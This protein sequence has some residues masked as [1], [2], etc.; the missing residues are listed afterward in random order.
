M[1]DQMEEL[2]ARPYADWLPM[3]GGRSHPRDTPEAADYVVEF[4][5]SDDPCHPRNWP[6]GR[7]ALIAIIACLGSFVACFDSAIFAAGAE[8]A[9]QELHVSSEVIALGTSLFVLGFSFGPLFAPM[10][11]MVGRRWPLLI[12]MIGTS[13]FAIGCATAKD[14][15]TLLICRFF[16]G[17]FGS[18]PLCVAP[19]VLADLYNS[20]Y[21]GVAVSLYALTVYGG[22]FLG[23]V[24]G[25]QLATSSL[26]W[27]WSLYL[28]AI[29]GFLNAILLIVPYKETFPASILVQKAI[30]LR[31][32]TRN[33]A[34]HAEHERLEFDIYAMIGKYFTRPLR[35]LITEPIVLLI[36]MYMSFIYGLVYA[37]LA[38]LP[39]TFE[40]TYNMDVRSSNLPF[41]AL[42]LGVTLSVSFILSQQR[43]YAHK[44]QENN[45]KSVPEWRLPPVIIGGV[46]FPIGLFW[47]AWTAY[48]QDIH[49]MVPVVSCVLIGF[50][51]L[52]IFLPCF[53]YLI[54]AYLPVAASAVAAN[55]MLR[56]AVAAAFPLFSRQLFANLGVQWAGTLLG[57]LAT[58]MVPIPILFRMYEP[59][60]LL[61]DH[62]SV[63]A[64]S[65]RRLL[66][67][68]LK[69]GAM[70]SSHSQARD[71]PTN[72]M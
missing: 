56:S 69:S 70:R 62:V 34:I 1:S 63:I 25:A 59:Q 7:K 41:L 39:Y 49:W 5:G 43:G 52:C 4:D 21:R 26:G 58:V 14:I 36:S 37:F 68:T 18:S 35:L 67:D 2:K 54:D 24:I 55:V 16:S 32:Q 33:W 46:L 8:E 20:T 72:F 38:A 29:L 13:I 23:P 31:K 22:P 57:C 27:R 40:H 48:S 19:G 10:S 42:L 45:G 3:G 61:Q 47:F 28:P 17:V 9:S 65:I 30:R 15:Q 66:W 51:L 64:S 53:N 11:E 12:S 44:L 50:G 60:G 6:T 71:D